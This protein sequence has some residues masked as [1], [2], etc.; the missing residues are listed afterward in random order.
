MLQI[1]ENDN[2][3]SLLVPKV[4]NADKTT[5]HLVRDR[6]S[7]FDYAL[8]FIPFKFVKKLFLEETSFLRM[9]RFAG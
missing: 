5:Q 9:P 1:M 7:V 8:R 4:L 2:S 3:V 6:V